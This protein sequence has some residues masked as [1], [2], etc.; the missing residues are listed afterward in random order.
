MPVHLASW[1]SSGKTSDNRVC[2]SDG[3]AFAL[4]VRRVPFVCDADNDNGAAVRH[5]A[6]CPSW[7]TFGYRPT[8]VHVMFFVFSRYNRLDVARAVNCSTRGPFRRRVRR[9]R[10]YRFS[11]EK[12]TRVCRARQNSNGASNT[13][14][15]DQNEHSRQDVRAFSLTSAPNRT[16]L[17][18]RWVVMNAFY[19][20][21]NDRKPL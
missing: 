21:V 12:I 9:R 16:T 2:P 1:F 5:N 18:C 15:T 7:E 19:D 20:S 3:Y 6:S 14:R 17:Y 13:T 4:H 11:Y 8:K 10:A